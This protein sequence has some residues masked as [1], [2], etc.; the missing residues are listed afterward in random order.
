MK[1]FFLNCSGNTF[2]WDI[3]VTKKKYIETRTRNTLEPLFGERVAVIRTGRGST[4]VIGTVML[5]GIMPPDKEEWSKHQRERACIEPGSK[6]DSENGKW[7]YYLSEPEMFK[8][9]SP[10]PANAVR[11][12]R[13]W[14]EW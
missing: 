14:C 5:A 11:H 7:C 3:F 6:W 4:V 9:P 8:H 2:D 13:S 10:V 12:G 1:G